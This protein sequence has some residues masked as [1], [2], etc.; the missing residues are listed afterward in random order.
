MQTRTTKLKDKS[1]LMLSQWKISRPCKSILDKNKLKS[2]NLMKSWMKDKGSRKSYK[3]SSSLSTTIT[4]KSN[5]FLRKT[6][7]YFLI[8]SW[9]SSKINMKINSLPISAIIKSKKSQK[10]AKSKM[11]KLKAYPH[12]LERFKM[13][14]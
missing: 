13:S 3:M 9:K 10:N 12:S 5:T 14:F 2:N 7:A 6:S 11:K 1:L 8:L 4:M